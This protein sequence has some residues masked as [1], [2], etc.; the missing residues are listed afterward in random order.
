[1]NIYDGPLRPKGNGHEMMMGIVNDWKAKNARQVRLRMISGKRKG[2]E[3]TLPEIVTLPTDSV[4][5]VLVT[6][7]GLEGFGMVLPLNPESN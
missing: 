2:N 7:P 5:V 4:N 3:V 6:L 1:M